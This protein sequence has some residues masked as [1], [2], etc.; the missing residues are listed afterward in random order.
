ML[1][2]E[3]VL[4]RSEL[5]QKHQRLVQGER[6]NRILEKKRGCFRWEGIESF[7]GAQ[8][9]GSCLRYFLGMLGQLIRVN[10]PVYLHVA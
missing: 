5:L 7:L 10:I 8:F 6:A 1:V 9:F 4:L 3:I 2:E